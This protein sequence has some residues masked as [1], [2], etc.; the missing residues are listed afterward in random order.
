MCRQAL[1][2]PV[3]LRQ[4]PG[5]GACAPEHFVLLPC[6][7]SGEKSLAYLGNSN[8]QLRHIRACAQFHAG[9]IIITVFKGSPEERWVQVQ[10][11][12]RLSQQRQSELN[13]LAG[14]TL[15]G[16]QAPPRPNLQQRPF[17]SN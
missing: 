9:R 10:I 5:S 15:K 6:E 2:S 11:N 8:I 17:S 16:P 1:I 13:K 3:S 14:K 4:I 12:F 7:I